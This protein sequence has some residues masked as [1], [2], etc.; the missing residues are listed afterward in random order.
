M[1]QR[2]APAVVFDLDGTLIDSAPQ[3]AAAVNATLIE[4]RRSPL[5]LAT[6]QSMTGEGAR[7][8]IERAFQATGGLD[9]IDLGI[10][11]ERYLGHYLAHHVSPDQ[12]FPGVVHVLKDLRGRG[13]IMGICTNK[14]GATTRPVLRSLG[15]DGYFAAVVTADDTQFRKPDGRHV[16]QT[17][18]AMGAEPSRT[19]YVGDSNADLLAA[20]SAGIPAVLVSYGYG[21]SV[22]TEL[23]AA[24]IDR[25]CDL[26]A[27]LATLV[28]A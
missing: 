24:C 28:T 3:V 7:I 20:Q 1:A 22:Q 11:V 12:I 4:A 16:T 5:P 2:A 17:I 21:G 10:A 26:P 25:F 18:A 15:L 23:A 19:V 6:I 9:A 13:T 8:T 14:P 27:V